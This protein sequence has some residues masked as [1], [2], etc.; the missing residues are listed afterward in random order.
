MSG[1]DALRSAMNASS[2]SFLAGAK[3]GARYAAST[4]F[5]FWFARHTISRER[6]CDHC[7]NK[8]LSES[9]KSTESRLEVAPRV[10]GAQEMADRPDLPERINRESAFIEL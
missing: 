3:I 9:S 4:A 5:H 10:G 7:S 1:I 2:A 6:S 8:L